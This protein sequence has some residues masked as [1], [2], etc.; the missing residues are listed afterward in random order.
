MQERAK[1]AL[2]GAA[3]DGQREKVVIWVWSRG[4]RVKGTD[5]Q[6]GLRVTPSTT[7][8]P[9]PSGCTHLSFQGRTSLSSGQIFVETVTQPLLGDGGHKAKLPLVGTGGGKVCTADRF[10]DIVWQQLAEE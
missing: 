3:D 7:P 6:R 9:P 2:I 1:E 8:P 10:I 4:F 5:V